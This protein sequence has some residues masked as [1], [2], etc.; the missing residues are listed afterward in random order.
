MVRAGLGVSIVP[1]AA[2][3]LKIAD[4]RLRPLKLRSQT[5]V[6]LFLVWRREYDNPLLPSLIDIAGE[7]AAT[8]GADH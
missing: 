1:A 7:L 6:E 8:N 2:A 4:V 5:P 3:S